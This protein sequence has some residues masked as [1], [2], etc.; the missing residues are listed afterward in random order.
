MKSWPTKKLGK[1]LVVVAHPDDEILWCGGYILRHREYEW[2]IISVCYS[3]Y[4]P[5][6]RTFVRSC[7]ELDVYDF[8]HFN[9]NDGFS[10]E[11][12][13]KKLGDINFNDFEVVITH[14]EI[15]GEY[16]NEDHKKI[17]KVI[18]QLAKEKAKRLLNFSYKN[19]QYLQDKIDNSDFTRSDDGSQE[20][21]SINRDADIF[22]FLT[23]EEL[24]KK[25]TILQDI[26][27]EQKIDFRNLS[28]PCPNP[29]GFKIIKK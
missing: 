18:N 19:F 5:R 2:K 23:H 14:D 13:K 22:L 20:F 16:G 9:F 28:W 21:P 1:A 7:H 15:C 6:N 4:L 12:L 10:E 3:N 24:K 25:L 8:D 29:E 17:G 11:D 26:Y 27:L